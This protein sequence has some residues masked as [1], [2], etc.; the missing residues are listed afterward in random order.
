MPVLPY[1]ARFCAERC[2]LRDHAQASRVLRAL[3]RAGV[4]ACV[5]TLQPRSKPDG[6]K[7]Y[8]APDT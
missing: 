5:G 3:E 7:L 1:S 8:A 2:E 4:V 6:T